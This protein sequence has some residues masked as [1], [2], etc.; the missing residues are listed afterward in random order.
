MRIYVK[1]RNNSKIGHMTVTPPC[2][3]ERFLIGILSWLFS[4]RTLKVLQN[5]IIYCWFWELLAQK[6]FGALLVHQIP[7]NYFFNK[8]MEKLT[9]FMTKEIIF[10][11]KFGALFVH[12]IIFSINCSKSIAF[13]KK[14]KCTKSAPNTSKLFFQ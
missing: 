1:F 8:I 9:D 6:T 3:W 10:S 2:R 11:I 7:L 4:W 12:Q 5:C 14:R 13:Q